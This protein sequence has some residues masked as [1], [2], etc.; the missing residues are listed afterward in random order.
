MTHKKRNIP[1]NK[2]LKGY[3]YLK[4]YK[5][6]HPRG[7][8]GKRTWDRKLS[9]GE[10]FELYWNQ[11]KNTVQIAEMVNS[12]RES[13]RKLLK[14]YDIPRKSVKAVVIERNKTN[15]PMKNPIY[16]LRAIKNY[17]KAVM[18]RKELKKLLVRK[19][20]SETRRRLIREGKVKAFGFGL[21][22]VTCGTK[23]KKFPQYR[24][25]MLGKGNPNYK[26]K[27]WRNDSFIEKQKKSRGLN[28]N[29][30]EKQFIDIIKTNAL[31]YKYVG[32][33]SLWIDGKNPDFISTDGSKRI[34]EVFG[35]YWHTT[36]CSNYYYTEHGRKDFFAKRGYEC[37]VIWD[38][39]LKNKD[40]LL[41]KI[42]SFTSSS[43]PISCTT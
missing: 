4:H 8:L 32:D 43:I 16:K 37:L 18:K 21:N 22:P 17:Q 19:K 11:N 9:K 23:G 12:N 3:E 2:G 41:N 28:P 25:R 1:W 10:L 33:F 27:L 15:N 7:T 30:L 35:K 40:K 13:I 6:G 26:G 5:N 20:Q 29:G 34:I 36:V 14:E 42:I 38:Y 39:E 31:P 24:Q